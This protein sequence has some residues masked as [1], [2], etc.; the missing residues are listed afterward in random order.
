MEFNT[1]SCR[2]SVSEDCN[3][4]H[5]GRTVEGLSGPPLLRYRRNVVRTPGPER[6]HFKVALIRCVTSTLSFR[7]PLWAIALAFTHVGSRR[8]GPHLS[9]ITRVTQGVTAHE[10]LCQGTCWAPSSAAPL[11]GPVALP[12]RSLVYCQRGRRS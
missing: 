2:N 5:G 7:R 12:R 9:L 8:S 10:T 4:V 11:K 1:I 6:E 3:A